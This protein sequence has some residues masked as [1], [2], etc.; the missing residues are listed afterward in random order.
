MPVR[1]ILLA[2]TLLWATPALAQNRMWHAE[3]QR[4]VDGQGRDVK[5][6]GAN[7]GNWLMW[8]G[9]MFGGALTG[10]ESVMMDRLAQTIGPEAAR[11]FRR[12]VQD[13]YLTEDDVALMARTGFNTIRLPINYRSLVT[14][15]DC[16]ACDGQGWRHVDQLLGWARAHGMKVILD[17]HA[18]PG[19]QSGLPIADTTIGRKEFWSNRSDQVRAISLWAEIARRYA[20]NATVA[21]YD[22]LNEP[23]APSSAV[24]ASFYREVITAIRQNDPDHMIWL[25]GNQLAS[26]LSVFDR[27]FG[28]NI[29][30][31]AHVYT[32]P[33]DR[34]RQRYA[35][36][37][38]LSQRLNAPMWIGE[39]GISDKNLAETVDMMDRPGIVGWS[40][41][42]WKYV[43]KD[44][45][46]CALRPPQE[47]LAVAPWVSGGIWRWKP[48]PDA[49]ARGAEAFVGYMSSYRCKPNA[50]VMSA[51]QP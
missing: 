18:A 23:Q 37:A 14:D 1:S 4:V 9:Y 11:R 24:L 40:Y 39:F 35:E 30:Y 43:A 16:L 19:A 13:A 44:A 41:W 26:D 15:Q 7:V 33:F 17:L 3:G 5:I 48:K 46:P 29:G 27:P 22:V 20:G 25:E 38:A 2:A 34:R 49:V 36:A 45:A 6:R 51:L 10:S 32:F 12:D 31:S 8:E 21:G 47:W 42:S 50:E 28:P